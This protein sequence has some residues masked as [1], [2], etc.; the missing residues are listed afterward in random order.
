MWVSG[1]MCLPLLGWVVLFYYNVFVS[2]FILMFNVIQPVKLQSMFRDPLSWK[3]Y[4]NSHL[5]LPKQSQESWSFLYILKFNFHIWKEKKL[6]MLLL[7]APLDEILFVSLWVSVWIIF[8]WFLEVKIWE[9]ISNIKWQNLFDNSCFDSKN[10]M[11][12]S[13]QKKVVP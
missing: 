11:S 9:S 1:L 13:F 3:R 4:K 6:K 7:M 8:C 5:F 2:I 10:C 12:L